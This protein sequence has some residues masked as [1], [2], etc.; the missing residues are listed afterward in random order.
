MTS[1]IINLEN[2][3]AQRGKQT[4]AVGKKNYNNVE[5]TAHEMSRYFTLSPEQEI[6]PRPDRGLLHFY[7]QVLL[8]KRLDANCGEVTQTFSL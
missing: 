6:R 1:T 7:L 8:N 3:S 2:H 5:K 4:F